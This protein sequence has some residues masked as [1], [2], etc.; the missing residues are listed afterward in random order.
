MKQRRSSRSAEISLF[1][2]RELKRTIIPLFFQIA[3]SSLVVTDLRLFRLSSFNRRE[4]FR[5]SIRRIEGVLCAPVSWFRHGFFALFRV[6]P[7]RDRVEPI[8][9]ISTERRRRF[10]VCSDL[11]RL[12]RRKEG[13]AQSRRKEIALSRYNKTK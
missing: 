3:F 9:P 7:G 11:E 4:I 12:G 13:N 5:R 2:R 6:P 1:D 10:K 8:E